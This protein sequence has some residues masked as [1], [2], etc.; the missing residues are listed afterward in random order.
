MRTE[1]QVFTNA[2]IGQVRKVD[3]NNTPYF[4]GKDV[5]EILGY[6]R[7]DHAI[8]KHVDDDDKLMYQFG[9]SGQNRQRFIALTAESQNRIG[10][11][12]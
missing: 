2:K 8:T 12:E 7:P 4:V 5:A 3:I 6:S 1:I 10:M 9:T 11:E